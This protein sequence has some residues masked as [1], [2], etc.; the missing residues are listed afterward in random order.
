MPRLQIKDKTTNKVTG[1]KCIY[2]ITILLSLYCGVYGGPCVAFRMDDFQDYWITAGQEAIVDLFNSRKLPLT[3]GIISNFFG[4]DTAH[5]THIVNATK[6]GYI[7]VASHGY[8]HEDFTTF[9]AAD[10]QTLLS[11][12]IAQIKQITGITVSTFIPPYNAWNT[13]TIAAMN[14]NKITTFSSEEDLD[15]PPFPTGTPYHYPIGADTSYTDSTWTWYYPQASSVV[16]SEITA[17]IRR[18][19]YAAVMLHPMEFHVR[20]ATDY[21]ALNTTAV[22]M[23]G[24]VLTKVTQAGYTLTTIGGLKGCIGNTPPPN[25]PQCQTRQDCN[26]YF[27][28]ACFSMSCDTGICNCNDN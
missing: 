27:A 16:F 17:Q 28:D 6:S 9:S 5:V 12:S 1:M 13:D 15:M 24:D 4:Q 2:V 14:T 21:G 3:I 8:N 23:V 11:E 20:G 25:G 22:S 7:E 10:Q 19:G 18:G 26:G